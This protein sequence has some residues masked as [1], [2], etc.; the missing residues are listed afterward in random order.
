MS[1]RERSRGEQGLASSPCEF[2][3]E[4]PIWDDRDFEVMGWHDATIW[5]MCA[6]RA[7]FEFLIDLDYISRWVEPKAGETYFKFG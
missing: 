4:K 7:A 3:L 2:A 5:S 1:G 6:D